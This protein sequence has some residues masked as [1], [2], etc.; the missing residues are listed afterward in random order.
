M[1][2]N[3]QPEGRGREGAFSE[4]QIVGF[5]HEAGPE[6]KSGV[7]LSRDFLVS[8]NKPDTQPKSRLSTCSLA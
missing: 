3:T 1:S 4:G 8:P 2:E 5:L 6:P 7:D